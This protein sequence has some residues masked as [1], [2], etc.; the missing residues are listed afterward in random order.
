M[1]GAWG[2]RGQGT[3]VPLR[4]MQPPY[5]LRRAPVPTVITQSEPMCGTRRAIRGALS[6]GCCLFCLFRRQS[7]IF[8][9]CFF[10][11]PHRPCN[12]PCRA[13]LPW[14]RD[15]A[16]S[17]VA[18]AVAMVDNRHGC[19]DPSPFGKQRPMVDV[20]LS[21]DQVAEALPYTHT[22]RW[23]DILEGKGT[24]THC[25]ARFILHQT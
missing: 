15:R 19:L 6:F 5:P 20:A 21:V 9:L 11:A 22:T 4:T 12:P 25:A 3:I 10:S 23:R 2:G 7:H 13:R 17:Q 18:M 24:V 8:P 1:W 16:P 14:L